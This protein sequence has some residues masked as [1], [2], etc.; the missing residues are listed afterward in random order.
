[1]EDEAFV[2]LMGVLV[3][4]INALG[5]KTGRTAFDA[6]D[7]VAFFEEKFRQVR[8]VLPGYSG[9]DGFFLF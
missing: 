7:F 3:Q 4:M 9:D 5:V 2:F 1:V 8:A 6:V